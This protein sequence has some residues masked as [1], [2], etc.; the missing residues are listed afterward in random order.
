[1]TCVGTYHGVLMG[2]IYTIFITEESSS[3][4]SSISISHENRNSNTNTFSAEQIKLSICKTENLDVDFQE[5]CFVGCRVI[6]VHRRAQDTPNTTGKHFIST[7]Y[8]GHVCFVV[9]DRSSSGSTVVCTS[10]HQDFTNQTI[11]QIQGNI[12]QVSATDDLLLLT[13]G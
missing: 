6:I 12:K 2:S 13:T 5:L 9:H 8:K 3:D 4:L 1:M 10:I 11:V 7:L